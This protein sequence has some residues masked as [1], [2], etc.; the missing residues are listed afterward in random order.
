MIAVERAAAAAWAG[1]ACN[2][3]NA[4]APP[5]VDSPAATCARIHDPHRRAQMLRTLATK[6]YTHEYTWHATATRH[7][8]AHGT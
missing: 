7:R 4:P 1:P 8:P 5:L 2:S 3:P 6:S